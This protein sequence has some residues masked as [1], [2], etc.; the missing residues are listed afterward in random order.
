MCLAQSDKGV[1]AGGMASGARYG[2]DDTCHSD[3]EGG[4]AWHDYSGGV[5]C[6]HER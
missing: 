3:S 2:G 4:V 5:L 1:G 6:A